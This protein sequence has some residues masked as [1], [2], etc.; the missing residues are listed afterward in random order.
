MQKED[1]Y[2]VLC[3]D[4]HAFTEVTSSGLSVKPSNFKEENEVKATLGLF[5]GSR[6][7]ELWILKHFFNPYIPVTFTIN[8]KVGYS[9]S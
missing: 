6:L 2:P 8:I 4:L 1:F 3:T 7:T 5:T 9:T